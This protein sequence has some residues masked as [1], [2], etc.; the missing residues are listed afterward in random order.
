VKTIHHLQTAN[1]RKYISK[2]NMEKFLKDYEE[3][4]KMLHGLEKAL[5]GHQGS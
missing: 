5:G 2:E 4:S 1:E 3:C